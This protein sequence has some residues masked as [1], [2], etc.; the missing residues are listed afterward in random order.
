MTL[1]DREWLSKIFNDT[2]RCAVSLQ[3]LSF[4]YFFAKINDDNDDD[5][6]DDIV[7]EITSVYLNQR[8]ADDPL[9]RF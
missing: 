5:N 7:E 9:S 6:D 2:K 3:Q 8:N 1:S 4:L